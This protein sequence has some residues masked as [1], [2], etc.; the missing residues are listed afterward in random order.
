[1]KRTISLLVVCILAV[2]CM[3]TTSD[4]STLEDLLAEFGLAAYPSY[5]SLRALSA[6]ARLVEDVEFAFDRSPTQH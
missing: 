1:M 5:Y 3:G 6:Y 4:S 2:L